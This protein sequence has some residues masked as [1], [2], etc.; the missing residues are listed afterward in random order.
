MPE[1]NVGSRIL[2]SAAEALAISKGR[3]ET[4]SFRT[5][6]PETVEVRRIR[7][8][9]RMS[10]AQFATAF[11]LNISTLRNWEQG[12]R[13]PIRLRGP[14][15]RVSPPI[16][17]TCCGFWRETPRKA[18]PDPSVACLPFDSGPVSPYPPRSQTTMT[19]SG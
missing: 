3:L 9:A 7:K 18:P 17:P 1:I 10:R 12:K 14:I 13:R 11:G 6:V 16:R 8:Q 15:C 4:S 2:E 19:L 5:H